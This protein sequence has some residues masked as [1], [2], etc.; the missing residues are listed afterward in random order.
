MH[1]LR[2][3][4]AVLPSEDGDDRLPRLGH[5]LMIGAEHLQRDLKLRFGYGG[6]V[7]HLGD[8]NTQSSANFNRRK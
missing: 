5:A 1:F 7:R 4:W 2:R 8:L 6:I 3:E